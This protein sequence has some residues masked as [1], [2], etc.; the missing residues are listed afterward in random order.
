M[1]ND[2]IRV[3]SIMAL[4]L[5]K[6][7][8]E[9]RLVEDGSFPIIMA[10]VTE[11]QVHYT[12]VPDGEAGFTSTGLAFAAGIDSGE[13]IRAVMTV[14]NKCDADDWEHAA[15]I[16]RSILGIPTTSI[17]SSYVV[18]DGKVDWAEATEMDEDLNNFNALVDA[19]IR[20]A[21]EAAW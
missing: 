19:F 20:A 17:I 6:Q 15:V 16:T 10:I 4:A 1:S 14:T 2:E 9:H 5:M 3:E 13:T 21:N 12:I 11:E 18:K 8:V 7:F